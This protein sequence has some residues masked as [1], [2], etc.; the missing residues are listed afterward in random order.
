MK[1][2]DFF[3][4]SSLVTVVSVSAYRR[5]G[6][7]SVFLQLSVKSEL[8]GNVELGTIAAGSRPAT[9]VPLP[10]F[11]SSNILPY[12]DSSGLVKANMIGTVTSGSIYCGGTYVIGG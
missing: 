7:V 11:G 8:S 12:A 4:P 3:T 6:V 10:T 1:I 2:T 9:T 5:G